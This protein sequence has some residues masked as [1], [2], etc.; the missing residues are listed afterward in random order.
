[1]TF[2]FK[3]EGRL[4]SLNE[5]LK[6]P[7]F[8]F[9]K[10]RKRRMVKRRIELW[11]LYARIPKF[12]GQVSIHFKWVEKDRRRDYD[13]IM[14]GS[15]IILDALVNQ[16]RIVNDS[17]KWLHPPT[18]SFEVDKANPRIEVTISSSEPETREESREGF[19]NDDRGIQENTRRP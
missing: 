19:K 13:N 15:K 1:M 3:M 17:Q 14:S 8:R 9:F 2:T 11:I 10:L 12:E 18:H 16:R 5:T 7:R 4:E 6:I